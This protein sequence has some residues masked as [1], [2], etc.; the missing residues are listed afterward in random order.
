MCVGLSCLTCSQN[1]GWKIYSS[2]LLRDKELPE[3][4]AN[5]LTVDCIETVEASTSHNTTGIHGSVLE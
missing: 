2:G 1:M 5:N 4:K 3:R